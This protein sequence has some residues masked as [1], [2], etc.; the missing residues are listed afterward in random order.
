MISRIASPDPLYATSVNWAP[1]SI[2]NFTL[3]RCVP[4]PTPAN[5]KLRLLGLAFAAFRKSCSDLNGAPL[6]TIST[7]AWIATSPIS[8]KSLRVS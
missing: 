3:L 1:E 7:L 6:G 2:A 5:A 8:V 4:L